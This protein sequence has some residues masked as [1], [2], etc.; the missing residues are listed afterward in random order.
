MEFMVKDGPHLIASGC[1]PPF[2]PLLCFILVHGIY[3]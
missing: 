2:I 1:L 3:Q